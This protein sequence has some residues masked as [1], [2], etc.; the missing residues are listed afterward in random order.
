[1]VDPVVDHI[2][3]DV[4]EDTATETGVSPV[5]WEEREDELVDWSTQDGE[6][7]WWHDQ[8]VWVHWQVVVNTVHQEVK[9]DE[10][11]VVWQVVIHVEQKSVE[12][13]LQETPY[14]HTDKEEEDGA[15]RVH[16]GETH[17]EAVEGYWK[18][19]CWDDPPGG[20]GDWFQKV[21]E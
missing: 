5:Q 18:P 8:T 6:H 14:K 19:N 21:A 2:V 16:V 11:G 15:D 4:A 17:S 13:V 12:D 20:Q 9:G 7:D 10:E 1:M 3:A